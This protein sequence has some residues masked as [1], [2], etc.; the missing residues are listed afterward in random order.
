MRRRI[1]WVISTVGLLLVAAAF[2]SGDWGTV[3]QPLAQV[4]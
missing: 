4:I 3:A 1:K 2:S